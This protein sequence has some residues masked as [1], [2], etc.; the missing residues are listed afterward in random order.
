MEINHVM[1]DADVYN[2]CL[3]IINILYNVMLRVCFIEVR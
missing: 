2:S 3:S 1:I